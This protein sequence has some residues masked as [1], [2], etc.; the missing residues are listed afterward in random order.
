MRIRALFFDVFGTLVNWR[1]AI[2]RAYVSVSPMS[3]TEAQAFAFAD[4]WRAAY[5]EAIERVR[6][7]QEPWRVLDIVHAEILPAVLSSVGSPVLSREAQAVLVAAWDRLDPWPD[8]PAALSE[9]RTNY[10][11]APVSNAS[12]RQMIAISRHAGF[13]W[14]VILGA[15]V[16]RQFKTHPSVYL[17]SAAA[18][19]LSPADCMLVAAH[20][21]DLAGA[22]AVGMRTAFVARP[23][24]YGPAQKQDL[25]ADSSCDFAAADLRELAALLAVAGHS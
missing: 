8:A 2:A 23:T 7:G 4:A 11:V 13:V 19:A 15:Q 1:P 16:A 14:D 10:I 12:F 22:R 25:C 18:I 24:E 9:L 20:N 17:E 3:V 21:A 6:L 5:F